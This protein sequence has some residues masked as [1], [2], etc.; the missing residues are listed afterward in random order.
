MRCIHSICILAPGANVSANM[1]FHPVDVSYHEA[2]TIF[3][4]NEHE[5]FFIAVNCQ[6]VLSAKTP[7]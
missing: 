5:N 7:N 1:I 4:V 2:Y 3:T 6:A